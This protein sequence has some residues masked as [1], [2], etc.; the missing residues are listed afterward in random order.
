MN[1][2]WDLA[3][4]ID[5]SQPLSFSSN[6]RYVEKF[7]DRFVFYCE[8]LAT[9]NKAF[10]GPS[11]WIEK[12]QREPLLRDCD[13]SSVRALKPFCD[14]KLAFKD[15]DYLSPQSSDTTLASLPFGYSICIIDQSTDLA[16]FY[17]DCS[18]S[19]RDTL[20]LTFD[21]EAA[22]AVF[23][24]TT[25]AAVSRYLPVRNTNLADITVVVRNSER[26]H[27]LS[28]PLVCHTINDILA[29]DLFPKYRVDEDLV[30]SRKTAERLGLVA[31][32]QLLAW[33]VPI[34]ST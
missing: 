30:A 25:I 1:G 11:E 18:E 8:D 24:D 14:L 27:K 15:L 21:G 22:F 13:R 12:L 10:I 6:G 23:R 17:S 28:A 16:D 3:I 9:R 20:D 29:H 4:G 34:V 32:Y 19:D 7:G 2:F 26:G 33:E 5:L 31:R